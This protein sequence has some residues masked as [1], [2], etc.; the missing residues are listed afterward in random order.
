MAQ[1]TID[2]DVNLKSVE[3]LQN[4]LRTLEAEFSTL[5]IGS[6]GFTELG[7]KIKG[8]RSQLKD[9]E[10]Q[11]EGLDKEQRATALVDTF[12]GLVGAVG[13]VSSAFI[14][15]GAESSAIE[16]AEKKLLGILGVV[17]GLRDASNGLIAV[18][19]LLGGSFK[20]AFTDATGAINTTKVALTG[21]GIGALIAGVTLLVTNFDSLKEAVFGVG[22]AFDFTDDQLKELSKDAGTNIA[23]VEILTAKVK[24]NTLAEGDRQKALKDL[25]EQYPAYFKNLG[26][27]INNTGALD[28]AKKKLI[29][30]L[31]REAKIRAATTKVEEVASKFIEER[32]ELQAEVDEAN[33][34]ILKNEQRI[35]NA[36][37]GIGVAGLTAEQTLQ[38]AL[39]DREA[40]QSRLL[41][42]QG[43]VAKLNAEEAAEINKITDAIAIETKAIEVNGGTTVKVAEKTVKV[44]KD[45]TKTKVDLQAIELKAFQDKVEA[46]RKI[47]EQQATEGLYLI[48]TQFAN[49][50]SRLEEQQE[51]ELKN[52]DLSEKA[53]KDIIDKYALEIQT[54]ELARQQ[55]V[56]E[57]NK[58]KAEKDLATAEK[59]AT[60]L[61]NLRTRIAD[62]EAVSEDQRRAREKEKLIQFYD[63]LIA[64]ATKNGL[65]ITALNKAKNDALEQQNEEFTTADLNKQKAYRQNLEDLVLNSA[66]SLIND[67]QSLNQNFDRDNKEAAKK[68]F[69]R[70]KSLATVSTLI[71]TYLAAQKA[72]TSQLT[73]TPDSPIRASIAA[74]V[75]VASGLARVA[76]IRS[77]QFDGD[78]A[79]GN[80]GGGGGGSAGSVSGGGT[81]ILNPF[82]TQ[83]GGTNILPPRLAPPSGGGQQTTQAGTNNPALGQT[84][85][86]RAYVLAGDVT[87][88]Q[89]ANE[90]INQKRQ[91]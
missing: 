26:D 15:F 24:D 60:D 55:A 44:A 67:L 9:V 76:I 89:V 19:K 63:E 47:D 11:F 51:E 21:L 82:S 49:N 32:L 57:F 72:Y 61:A 86:L 29:D 30:T 6:E 65:D 39:K 2:I 81:N 54:N 37:K 77:Q 4:E 13:A 52:K 7:N 66:L 70:E 38:G 69:E 75:A 31:I 35:A 22:D 20:T 25:Q 79:S 53:K 80:T 18:N 71:S 17:S 41:V 12:T 33:A 1:Y 5:S 40:L 90:K 45:T 83:G 16:D 85:I 64:E 78:N 48:T 8:V 73:L 10:L 88:A 87:D 84:P 56:D 14:A 27:D 74:A 3:D 46:Q 59:N 50:L 42:T 28:T 23:Q 62:A 43:S 58:T 91:L 34:N 68:A 36:R